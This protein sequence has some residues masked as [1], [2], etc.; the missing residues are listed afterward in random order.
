[1]PRHRT[2]SVTAACAGLALLLGSTVC[3]DDDL[4]LK[5]AS[6]VNE[7]QLHFLVM[8]PDKPVHHH[9]NRIVIDPAS[10]DTGWV[11]LTQCHDNLDAVPRAQITFREGFVRDLRIDSSRGAA[12]AWVDGPS[13]QLRGIE[14]GSRLCLSAQTRALRDTGGGYYNLNNGPYM[15]KF[16]D[17]YY[18]MRVTLDVDYPSAMLRLVDVSPQVTAGLAVQ[19]TPGRIHLD[20]LF[21]GELRTLIQFLRRE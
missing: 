14:P 8:P 19:E 15:R 7:G 13:I 11:S 3:A 18:P 2:E 5:S 16:L 10:L 1:M 6:A 21:E 12:E 20:A 9:Q 4:L 17:G